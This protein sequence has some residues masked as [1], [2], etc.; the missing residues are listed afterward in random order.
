M[1]PALTAGT[2]ALWLFVWFIWA[3]EFAPE[4]RPRGWPWGGALVLPGIALLA[5]LVALACA[6]SFALALL[7]LPWAEVKDAARK[8]WREGAGEKP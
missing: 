7:C 2:L 8:G 3:A 4:E 1:T 6:A 5:T